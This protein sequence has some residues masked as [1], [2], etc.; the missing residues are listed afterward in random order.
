MKKIKYILLLFLFIGVLD[1]YAVDNCTNEEMKRLKD[2]ASNVNFKTEYTVSP[3]EILNDEGVME[4]V[5]VSVNFKIQIINDNEDL[6]YYYKDNIKGEKILI[7]QSDLSERSFRDG[8]NIEFQIYSY[9]K[10]LCTNKLLR[11]VKVELPNYNMYYYLN[12]DKCDTYPEF[13]YCKEFLKVNQD[14]FSKIDKLFDEY[15]S[16]NDKENNSNS[17]KKTLNNLYYI[18]A[19]IAF[20]VVFT[21]I[22]IVYKRKKRDRI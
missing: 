7:N 18:I 8:E 3:R 17:L 21:I 12:K 1:V 20:I 19:G 5:D 22:I 11:T 9:S 2:L 4:L 16:N 13:Q 6:K 10:N 15:L 14:D